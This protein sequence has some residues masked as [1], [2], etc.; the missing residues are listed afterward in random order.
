[1]KK[2]QVFLW[3]VE[4]RHSPRCSLGVMKVFKL[5]WSELEADK[6]QGKHRPE[7]C[8]PII[9][10]IH[11]SPLSLK[12]FFSSSLLPQIV[13]IRL[14]GFCGFEVEEE[15]ERRVC[16]SSQGVCTETVKREEGERE[17]DGESNRE[18]FISRWLKLHSPSTARCDIMTDLLH[19]HNWWLV[20]SC[21]RFH[22]LLH[23]VR[24]PRRWER[25][26]DTGEM[27]RRFCEM[28]S[29]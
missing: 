22:T 11:I 15:R 24:S 3:K 10:L 17:R 12:T 28:A 19:M 21:H 14:V 26:N 1:M 4:T 9:L 18:I 25:E 6:T 8:H 16:V 5:C 7:Y 27:Q 13:V 29:W 2:R 23:E 20:M